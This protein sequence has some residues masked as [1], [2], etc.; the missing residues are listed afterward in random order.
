[1]RHFFRLIVC[2]LSV[3]ST[4]SLF[5]LAPHPC[6]LQLQLK[7]QQITVIGMR[8]DSPIILN[9]EKQRIYRQEPEY[10]LIRARSYAPGNI[11]FSDMKGERVLS[12]GFEFHIKSSEPLTG[13]FI[14]FVSLNEGFLRTPG[15]IDPQS[16]ITVQSLPEIPANQT[17]KVV[18]NTPDMGRSF[19]RQNNEN[20]GKSY[21]AV[22]RRAFFPVVFTAGGYEIRSGQWALIADFYYKINRVQHAKAAQLYKERFAGQNHA[23]VPVITIPPLLPDNVSA[24][25]GTLVAIIDVNSIGVVERVEL[26]PTVETAIADAVTVTLKD[27][28]FL[29]KLSEGNPVPARVQIPLKF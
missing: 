23:A 28:L 6:V 21:E 24:P 11:E 16:L 13:A 22:G 26:P 15:E 18:L 3:S 12:S 10:N 4:A 20:E 17:V 2:A 19:H 1:M 29:P 9:G 27:W 5:A 25:D 8:G 7:D 14:A